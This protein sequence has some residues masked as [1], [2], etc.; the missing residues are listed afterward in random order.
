MMKATIEDKNS[1][2]EIL[3]KAFEDNK[4]VNFI[5]QQDDKRLDRIR[6]LMEYSFLTCLEFGEVWLNAERNCCS[7]ILF[8]DRKRFSIKSL[9]LKLRLISSVIGLSGIY[10]VLKREKLVKDRYVFFSFDAGLRDSHSCNGYYLWFIGTD[11]VYQ[12]MGLGS[13]MIHFL[14]KRADQM[15][16]KL[17]LETSVESNLGWYKRFGF[18]IY[19]Q[20]EIGYTLYFLSN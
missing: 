5:V 20:L 6:S 3:S 9:L 12:G 2:T 18:K 11:P 10:K 1:V 4:S 14:K 8:P 16:R 7:L 15:H 17:Y 19:D 13:V